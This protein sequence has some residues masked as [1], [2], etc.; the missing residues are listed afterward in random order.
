MRRHWWW[1]PGWRPGRRLYAWHLTLRDQ[2]VSQGQADLRQ[3]VGA[4]QARLAGL[5]GLDL[6]P[7][8]WLH[9]TVQASAS[10]TRSAPRRGADRGGGPPS[11]RRLWRR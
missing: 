8:E 10:P 3:V 9:L 6:V 1:R 7:A 4:Y 11:L 5:A 2:T